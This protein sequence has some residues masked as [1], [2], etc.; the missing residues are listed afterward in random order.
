MPQ[1]QMLHVRHVRFDNLAGLT[2]NW[3]YMISAFCM[4]ESGQSIKTLSLF[5][6]ASSSASYFTPCN[7]KTK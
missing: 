6:F 5:S 7:F 3:L 4:E 1:S 2:I